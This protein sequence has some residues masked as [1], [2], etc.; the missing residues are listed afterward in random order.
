MAA[1]QQAMRAGAALPRSPM[2]A[3]LATGVLVMALLV[4][5]LVI[6]G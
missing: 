1:L 2:V 3:V 4:A 5:G 6:L